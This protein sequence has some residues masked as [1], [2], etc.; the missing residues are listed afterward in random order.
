MNVILLGPPGC[1]KGTQAKRLEK[2]KGLVQLSTGDMLRKEIAEKSDVGV[3]VSDVMD[4]GQLVSDDI[5]IKLISVRI[6]APDCKNGFILDGFPRTMAQADALSQML[7]HKGLSVGKVIELKVDDDAMISRITGR[8]SC[9]SCG[10]GY[11][12]EF[13]RPRKAG[14]C[15][16]CCGVVFTRRADD[17]EETVRS[18]LVAYREQTAPIIAFYDKMGILSRVDGMADIDKVEADLIAV[19]G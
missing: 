8:F 17:N 2:T 1:G 7:T 19:I 5:I 9:S 15:D 6:D 12:D 4:S 13:N 11:H 16:V 18:R 14:V 3:L 10:T